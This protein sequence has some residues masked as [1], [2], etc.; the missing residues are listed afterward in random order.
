MHST[1]NKRV[2]FEA[3]G[4]IMELSDLIIIPREGNKDLRK[5][6]V[7]IETPDGQ[8]LNAELRNQKIRLA[9]ENKLQVK[10]KI[11]FAYTFQGSEKN[12]K[13][14]NNIYIVEIKTC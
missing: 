9:K 4:T 6:M 8:R 10:D 12:G 1:Q 5:I 2:P 11:E 13:R 7:T 3:K 14:Y